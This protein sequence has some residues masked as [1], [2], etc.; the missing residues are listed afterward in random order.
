M[1]SSPSTKSLELVI[2]SKVVWIGCDPAS[3]TD[4]IFPGVE[5]TVVKLRGH[6][7]IQEMMLVDPDGITVES[8]MGPW[9]SFTSDDFSLVAEVRS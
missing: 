4:A 3:D 7:P 8:L 5:Y 2:G 6:F 9:W 1:C